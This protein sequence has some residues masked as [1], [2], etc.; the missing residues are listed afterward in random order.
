M[1]RQ[2]LTSTGSRKTLQL[3]GLLLIL[4][5]QITPASAGHCRRFPPTPC[6]ELINQS[7]KVMTYTSLLDRGPDKCLVANHHDGR[8]VSCKHE[9]VA[10]HGHAGG[11]NVDV[12][13]FTFDDD[14]YYVLFDRGTPVLRT[15]GVWTRIKDMQAAYCYPPRK[16]GDHPWCTIVVDI[17]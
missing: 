2:A 16:D 17:S 5:F 12:D 6:G 9:H 7:G 4:L 11:K 3:I 8:P 10:S 15:K 14:D 1:E 13:A